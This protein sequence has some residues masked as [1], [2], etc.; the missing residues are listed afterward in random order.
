MPANLDQSGSLKYVFGFNDKDTG[1]TI[2]D[3]ASIATEIGVSPT[4]LTISFEPEFEATAQDATGNTVAS[5]IGPRAGNFSMEGYSVCDDKLLANS[6]FFYDGKLFN[7]TS[8]ELAY[9]NQDFQTASLS[10]TTYSNISY[11][12][13]GTID[14]STATG[15]PDLTD[16][17]KQVKGHAYLVTVGGTLTAPGLTGQAVETGD[18]VHYDGSAWV[19]TQN[20]CNV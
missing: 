14:A 8:R 19:W 15:N 9:N 5:V 13:V 11:Y 20:P 7:V 4:S 18:S 6:F 12:C 17:T 10:G 16:A 2:T 1:T 3:V